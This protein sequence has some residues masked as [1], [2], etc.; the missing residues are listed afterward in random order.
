MQCYDQDQAI[1]RVRMYQ[2]EI[3]RSISKTEEH[4]LDLEDAAGH[5]EPEDAEQVRQAAAALRRGSEALREAES[6]LGDVHV[7]L[8]TRAVVRRAHTAD[9]VDSIRRG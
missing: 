5:L 9:I 2:P 1:D 8:R 4:Q 6:I 7:A 3:L